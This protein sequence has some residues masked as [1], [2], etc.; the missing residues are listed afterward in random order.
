[1]ALGAMIVSMENVCFRTEYQ[2]ALTGLDSRITENVLTDA[3]SRPLRDLRISV[4]DRCNLRCSYCMPRDVSGKK[5]SFLPQNELLS[6][7]EIHRLSRLFINLGVRK[8]RLTGG[9][10]MLRHRLERLIEKL[11]LLKDSA[12]R[13]IEIA[14]TTNGTLLASRARILKEAGLSRL[15]V[16]LDALSETTFHRMTGSGISVIRVLE[17]IAAAQ[18]AGLAPIKVNTVIRRG[19]NENE[20]IPLVRYFRNTGII[21]R[22]VEFMDVGTANRWKQ[23]EVI[24]SREIVARIDE[25]YPLAP[26]AANYQGEVARRW[27]FEDGAGEIGAISS[28]TQ[29]FCRECTRLRLSTDG[30]L[31]TCLFA[32]DGE[33]L[34]AALREDASDMALLQRISGLWRKREDRYSELR[35]SL[36]SGERHKIEMSYIG[37]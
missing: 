14:M 16:S 29:A 2:S 21:L 33:D 7:E 26:L 18:A 36:S 37:G 35:D 11:A 23:D 20:I 5:F 22:F 17:G 6:F 34:R 8:I 24:S 12:D 25:M 30:K 32:T 3:L 19:I 9:E 10:P 28:V 4:T 1:M 13:P 27:I 15:T 31:Y